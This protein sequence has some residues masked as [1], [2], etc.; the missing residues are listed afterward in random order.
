M[1][2]L[3]TP[4]MLCWLPCWSHW[5]AR[6]CDTRDPEYLLLIE[7]CTLWRCFNGFLEA[8]PK[9]CCQH[10]FFLVRP[11]FCWEYSRVLSVCL[12]F[13]SVSPV[14]SQTWCSYAQQSRGSWLR[15][16]SSTLL[17]ER[18]SPSDKS[19]TQPSGSDAQQ[20]YPCHLITHLERN[21]VCRESKRLIH[22][23]TRCCWGLTANP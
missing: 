22:S 7:V 16:A 9:K 6:P 13:T 20:S 17:L 21:T 11:L 5:K 23:A 18:P 8:C 1:I 12:R 14:W 15:G 3:I 10:V 4:A 19:L 2:C